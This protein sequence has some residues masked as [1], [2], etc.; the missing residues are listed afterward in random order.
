[1][2]E[3]SLLRSF[4]LSVI[5]DEDTIGADNGRE[6]ETFVDVRSGGRMNMN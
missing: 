4:M 3:A 2:T 6:T 5:V 1:M